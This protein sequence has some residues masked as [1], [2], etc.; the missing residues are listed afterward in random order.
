MH[1]LHCSLVSGTEITSR[2]VFNAKD[3]TSVNPIM[4][5]V[6]PSE[7]ANDSSKFIQII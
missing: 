6:Y 4:F 7:M 3:F 1:K 5:P 2:R